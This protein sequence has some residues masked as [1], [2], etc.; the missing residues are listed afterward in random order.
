MPIPRIP[1]LMGRLSALFIICS[2]ACLVLVGCTSVVPTPVGTREIVKLP[3]TRLTDV[4]L[5]NVA[6]DGL[7]TDGSVSTA[8]HGDVIADAFPILLDDA[9]EGTMDHAGD[10]DIF[11]IEAEKGKLYEIWL[12]PE[13][14]RQI[15]MRLIDGDGELVTETLGSTMLHAPIE[16]RYFVELADFSARYERIDYTLVVRFSP[17]PDDHG[18][19]LSTATELEIGARVHGTFRWDEDVDYFRFRAEEGQS[20]DVRVAGG[21]ARAMLQILGSTGEML[22]SAKRGT[23]EISWVPPV[24]GVYYIRTVAGFGEIGDYAV[25]TE[26]GDYEDDHSDSVS[27]ATEIQVGH[28]VHGVVDRHGDVDYFRFRSKAGR[29]YRVSASGPVLVKVLDADRKPLAEVGSYVFNWSFVDGDFEREIYVSVQALGDGNDGTYELIVETYDQSDDHGNTPRNATEISIGEPTNGVI[30]F[31]PDVDFFTFNAERHTTYRLLLEEGS[32][33]RGALFLLDSEGAKLEPPWFPDAPQDRFVWTAKSSGPYFVV[34]TPAYGEGEEYRQGDYSVSVEKYTDDHADD[35]DEATAIALDEAVTGFL[36]SHND[37]D[38]FKLATEPN[39]VYQIDVA[40]K[41]ASLNLPVLYVDYFAAWNRA[42]GK[43]VDEE[44]LPISWRASKPGVLHIAI[45]TSW[46]SVGYVLTVTEFADDHGD[47]PGLA[48]EVTIGALTEGFKEDAVNKDFFAFQAVK[49]QSYEMMFDFSEIFDGEVSLTSSD[50]G[51]VLYRTHGRDQLRFVWQAELTER[52]FVEVFGGADWK[53]GVY[54]LRIDEVEDKP[55]DE[56]GDRIATSTSVEIDSEILGTIWGL[57]DRDVFRFTA[58]KGEVYTISIDDEF[59]SDFVVQIVDWSGD[60]L[61]TRTNVHVANY[62]FPPPETYGDVIVWKA[63][64]AGDYF[65]TVAANP[66]GYER[67]GNYSILIVA[68]SVP[69]DYGNSAGDAHMIDPGDKVSG[70]IG[71]ARDVDVFRFVGESNQNYTIKV[72]LASGESS[73]FDVVDG[74]N[75]ALMSGFGAP[76]DPLPIVERNVDF[77]CNMDEPFAGKYRDSATFVHPY[78]SEYFITVKG[79]EIE[80]LAAYTLTL[81]KT[82]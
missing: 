78:Q 36:H 9:I 25:E 75:H 35:S 64:R 60:L 52:V 1:N 65:L 32:L 59:N 6:P 82:R 31:E 7:D 46:H 49:G 3:P 40:P 70:M 74:T 11:S 42:K 81:E 58:V 39:S 19:D 8:D 51:S 27:K 63:P 12:T 45:S 43:R 29:G 21:N 38:S 33:R 62:C 23:H 30:E 72:E 4:S 28:T 61:A 71:W 24:D 68:G 37:I 67:S 26:Y 66:Y 48:T 2:C 41:R 69:D 10:V 47:D 57:T 56:H 34:A 53:E 44:D 80:S 17:L 54:T 13:R 50:D 18:Y 5:T 73:E 79:P 16:G 22:I 15:K 77:G 20:Y 55:D 14:A 76:Q